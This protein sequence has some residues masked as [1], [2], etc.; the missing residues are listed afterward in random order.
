MSWIRYWLTLTP[1]PLSASREAIWGMVG[2]LSVCGAIGIARVLLPKM[3]QV[4][5]RR[6]GM[7]LAW[8][9]GGTG[10]WLLLLLFFRS[11]EIPLLGAR[12]WVLLLTG[13]DVAWLIW[14][15]REVRVRIPAQLAAQEAQREK[16]KYLKKKGKS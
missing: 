12:F 8:G 15:V 5:Y 13:A 11:E 9:V 14:W 2:L 6:A 1:P 16:G 4:M 7:R 3:R 10:A